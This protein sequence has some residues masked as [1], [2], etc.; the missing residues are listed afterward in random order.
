MNFTFY[1]LSKQAFIAWHGDKQVVT[2]PFLV[3]KD[4]AMSEQI[5]RN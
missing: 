5:G 4:D 2:R 3:L 1:F